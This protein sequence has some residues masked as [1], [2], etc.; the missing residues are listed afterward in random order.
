[1]KHPDVVFNG[2]CYLF[3]ISVNFKVAWKRD[4]ADGKTAASPRMSCDEDVIR[5]G[6]AMGQPVPWRCLSNNCGQ[7]TIGTMT[8]ICTSF[9]IE[10]NWSSGGNSVVFDFP[11]NG[12]SKIFRF[13]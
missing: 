4:T 3:Q 13:G 2:A 11:F 6:D 8:Y 12:L 7:S 9:S 1:M 10:E 5:R